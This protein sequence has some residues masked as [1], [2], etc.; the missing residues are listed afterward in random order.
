MKFP[1]FGPG[2]VLTNTTGN[3]AAER[4]GIVIWATDAMLVEILTT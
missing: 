3:V 4:A 2:T 1:L